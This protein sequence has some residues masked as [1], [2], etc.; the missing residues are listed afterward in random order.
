M[1][2]TI[3]DAEY[4]EILRFLY[5]EA[6][7]LDHRRFA[8]WLRLLADGIRYRVAVCVIR[9][10]GLANVEHAI[11]DEDSAGL[12]SRVEQ[13][14]NPRLTRAENPPSLTRRFVSNVQARRLESGYLVESNLLIYRTRTAVP[15]GSVYVGERSDTLVRLDG[16][17]RLAR[18]DVR[19]DQEIVFDGA[20]STIF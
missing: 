3:S 7:L 19:L 12:N 17:L 9:D 20:I 1:S 15:Q 8:D 16:E 10:G 5:A 11:I 4:S 18:R 6:A 13:I 14:S 2:E